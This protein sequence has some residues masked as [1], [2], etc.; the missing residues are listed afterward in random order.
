MKRSSVCCSGDRFDRLNLCGS[1]LVSFFA[2][3]P[4]A[5]YAHL[6]RYFY[7]GDAHPPYYASK[8]DP[9]ERG[10]ANDSELLDVF[11]ALNR[12]TDRV[13]EQLAEIWPPKRSLGPWRREHGMA[14]YLGDHGEQ[15]IGHDPPPHGNLVSPDVSRTLMAF[16]A[17][18]FVANFQSHSLVRMADIYATIA[19]AVGLTLNGSL[20]VGRSLLG[21]RS[22]GGSH[23]SSLSL[24]QNEEQ[25][26]KGHSALF[27]FSF[28]RPGL[29]QLERLVFSSLFAV[30]NF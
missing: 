21:G 19:A 11:L 8:V 5:S 23:G 28:Y 18:A 17:R 25:Q 9:S 22:S 29:C 15:L 10:Y 7:G 14:F 26:E 12:R 24:K 16:E 1:S 6:V 3:F 30:R 13:A 27:S 2:F 20:F 4:I